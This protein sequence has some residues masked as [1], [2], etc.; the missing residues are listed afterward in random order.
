MTVKEKINLY[1]MD[2]A[3]VDR[4][5]VGP[6]HWWN[7]A[8]HGVAR[9]G[10]STQF[11][12]SISMA[13]TWDPKLIQKMGNA[14]GQ[15][16]RA[17]HH[18]HPGRN[19]MY[20]GLTIWSP[21]INLARDPRWGRNEE[22][23][24][25]D[26][27][28]T[29]EM[30]ISFVK[31]LQGTDPKYLQAVATVK[32]FIANNTEHN[33]YSANPDISERDLREHY[34]PAYRAAVEEADVQSIM[35]AYNGFNG[36]PC[37]ANKWL[38][39]DV[40]RGEWGFS[41]TVVTDVSVPSRLRDD[42]HYTSTVQE[43]LA[44]MLTSGVDV[45]C[46]MRVNFNTSHVEKALEAGLMTMAD[47]D[48]A[49]VRNLTTRMQLGQ[50]VDDSDNPYRATPVSVIG[51]EK[52]L[53]IAREIAQKGA[54]LLKNEPVGDKPLLPL[55][56]GTIKKIIVAGP[57]AN[58]A[59]LGHYSGTPTHRVVTPLEGLRA[60]A[61]DV[62][63]DMHQFAGVDPQTIPSSV[64]RP[65]LGE[66]AHTGLK[67][68]Y[69]KGT[70]LAGEPAATRIDRNIDFLWKKPI[71][72]VD[73]LIP[74]K[75]FS[76]RWTGRLVP[77]ISGEYRLAIKEEGHMRV[78][79]DGK[80]L[81]DTW[82]AESAEGQDKSEVLSLQAGNSYD[83]KVEY[84]TP[85]KFRSAAY[86]GWT[87]PQDY[88]ADFFKPGFSDDSE[89]TLVVYAG[90]FDP[91]M[92]GEWT[93]KNDLTM[94]KDQRKDLERWIKRYKNVAVVL[95]GGTTVIEP[96]LFEHVP[97]VM[98]T[99]YAGQLGGHALADLI[100]GKVSPSGRL[101]LTWYISEQDIPDLDDYAIH[102]GRTYMYNKQP[103][104]FPFGHGLSYTTFEYGAAR[105][106]NVELS[107]EDTLI[108]EVPV[109]NTGKIAGEE[110]VQIYVHDL[111]STEYQPEKKLVAFGRT[112]VKPGEEAVLKLEIPM[113][114]LSYWDVENQRFTVEA[115]EFELLIG[116]SSEDI[117]QTV[118]FRINKGYGAR[119]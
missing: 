20:Q 17:R 70:D 9:N 10:L 44:V 39:T 92:S 38:L 107:S 110:V 84:F 36:V 94:P 1:R 33:R 64:L 34:M 49:I 51:N 3:P 47:L 28:L 27:L 106:S 79:L 59:F 74:G 61:K 30:A 108:V 14:I 99:W 19:G 22:T 72:N 29:S 114:R 91:A 111:E 50:M 11:P 53:G 37:S 103:V 105:L 113:D 67:G 82:E 21:T 98:H 100:T 35:T 77:E 24:G 40:L 76:V 31:G 7:E 60:G 112:L 62:Q 102:T 78:W 93:D 119:K 46:A 32:H 104:Q 4:L 109:R 65:P 58:S 25:E 66:E 73:P 87:L 75:I 86:L 15:E 42:H 26:P 71:A 8:L 12:Q 85:G 90:G 118:K 96:W 89:S 81:I 52:H 68:E 45:G 115:G 5:G 95:N 23:Y 80:Q 48:R 88:D 41:G 57:Y 101:P 13:S 55:Q 63:V 69:F 16:A 117:R 43:T 2:S 54:V 116:A 83:L 6:H 97:A 56:S 18:E